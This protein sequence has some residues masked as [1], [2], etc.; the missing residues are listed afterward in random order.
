MHDCSSIEMSLLI[1]A[2]A[3][4]LWEA[5]YIR[6]V[7]LLPHR[8]QLLGPRPVCWASCSLDTLTLLPVVCEDS[9]NRTPLTAS[10]L[11]DSE[12]P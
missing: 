11:P 5:T 8:K 4:P 2:N 3:S 10:A 12:L 1:G 7:I 9:T 6:R